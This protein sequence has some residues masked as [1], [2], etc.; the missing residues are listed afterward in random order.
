M[1]A[2]P[3]EQVSLNTVGQHA[4]FILLKITNREVI[5]KCAVRTAVRHVGCKAS[6]DE[7][8]PDGPQSLHFLDQIPVCKV[9]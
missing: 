7:S 6:M 4:L 8:A 1:K 2:A 3:W 5:E 9:N